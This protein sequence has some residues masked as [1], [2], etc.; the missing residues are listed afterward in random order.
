MA[1]FL[2]SFPCFPLMSCLAF[3]VCSFL[4]LLASLSFFFFPIRF[5]NQFASVV[6]GH[7]DGN[8]VQY[9][10]GS[11]PWVASGIVGFSRRE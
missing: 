11:L 9:I 3:L 2:F 4:F 10:R 8:Y 6:R 5:S 7:S 1:F